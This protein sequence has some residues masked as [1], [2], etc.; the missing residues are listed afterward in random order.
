MSGVGWGRAGSSVSDGD[1]VRGHAVLFG[2]GLTDNLFNLNQGIANFERALTPRARS[3]SMLI[4]YNGGHTLPS[5]IPPGFGTPGDPCSQQLGSPGFGDLELRFMQLNLKHQRTGLH[6]FGRY[7]LSTA[8]GRCVDERSV[9]PDRRYRLGPVVST[10]GGGLPVA[11]PVANGPISVAGSVRLEAR[12]STTAPDSRAFFALSVGTSPADA[13]IV[14]NN[15]MPLREARV[16]HGARRTIELPAVAVDV[17]AGKR[18][19]LTVSPV[20]DMFTGQTS[21]DPGVVRLDHVRLELN[22]N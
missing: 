15:T 19:F 22:R 5:V 14:Q 6:G 18:L 9:R 17:P 8:D 7:H 4:G 13:K 2:Q 11:V 12:V 21:R 16:V 10:T 20:A 1:G 3:R